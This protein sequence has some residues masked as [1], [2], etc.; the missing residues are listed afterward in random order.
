MKE[1]EK[2]KR[3]SKAGNGFDQNN[4]KGKIILKEK[5]FFYVERKLV[6]R[7]R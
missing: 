7:I 4:N 5:Y 2:G 3:K 1:I 6:L